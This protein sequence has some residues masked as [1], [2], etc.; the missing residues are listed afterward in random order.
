[1]SSPTARRSVNDFRDP[2]E[3]TR[4]ARIGLSGLFFWLI[5][6]LG[7]PYI[8]FWDFRGLYMGFS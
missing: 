3:K 4:H 8:W 7:M 2:Y 1:M 6:T 5:T